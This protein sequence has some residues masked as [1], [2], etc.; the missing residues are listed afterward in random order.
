MSSSIGLAHII[1]QDDGSATGTWNGFTLKTAF[2]PIFAFRDGKLHIVAFEGLLRPF[3]S[4]EP[5]PPLEFFRIVPASERLHVET[6]ARTLHL[7][8]AAACLDP[9]ATIFIN[10]DP[11]LFSERAITESVLRDIRLVLHEAGIDPRRV[12]CELT[13]QKTTSQEALYAFV[14][15]LRANGLRIA[16]DDYGS[17]ESDITRVRELRPD[18]VKFD[19][20]WVARLMDSGAGFALLTALVDSFAARGID[21]V[22]EGIEEDWQLELAER[23]GAAMVQGFVL[24]RPQIM[25]GQLAAQVAQQQPDVPPMIPPAPDTTHRGNSAGKTFGRRTRP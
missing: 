11:S 4:G 9:V 21:T 24:A 20:A 8:N 13:E 25:P 3:L 14:E 5:M 1:R 10:F 7:L 17:E 12:V 15:A 16:V 2:Q 23:S 6:L 19:A 18:V 22:F